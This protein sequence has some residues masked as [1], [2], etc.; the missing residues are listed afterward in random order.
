MA[1][2]RQIREAAIQFLYCSD[3]EGGANPASLREPF[4]LFMTE[5]DRRNL[6]SATLRT[7][8]HLAHGHEQR[9]NEFIQ[10]CESSSPHIAAL[11]DAEPLLSL[12]NRLRALESS[13][14]ISFSNL[15]RIPKSG[16]D[17]QIADQLEV[18]LQKFFAIDRDVS[19]N[20]KYFL[21]SASEFPSLKAH[22]EPLAAS[23]RRLDRISDRLRMVEN[24]DKFPEQADLSKIRE[25]KADIQKIIQLTDSLVDS[26]LSN[27]PRIDSTLSSIVENFS[28]ERIDPVDRSILRLATHEL[29]NT[30]TPAK[31][32]INEAIELAKRFGTSDSKRF[33]NGI[34]DSV[35]KNTRPAL[36]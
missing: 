8:Q 21:N 29:L 19:S 30:D 26:I 17:D 31:V 27:K 11:P 4:W 7:T 20:R 34:L 1:S 9:L 2:R 35:A 32:I 25:S 3:L 24:P 12:L 5:S 33:V 10:R 28:P 18:S 16:H 15:N 23:V 22:L 13:W 14:S 36:S 6:L